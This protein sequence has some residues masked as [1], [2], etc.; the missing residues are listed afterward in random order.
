VFANQTVE[1]IKKDFNDD[2]LKVK[3][4]KPRGKWG[5]GLVVDMDQF[6]DSSVPV[7]VGAMQSLSGGGKYAGV[8][9]IKRLEIKNRSS[10]AVNSVQL[11]WKI[12]TLDDPANVLL[13]G[14]TPFFNFW[15]GANSSQVVEIPTVYPSLLFKPLAKDGGLN[16]Q[17]KLT[18]GVQEAYFA[19]GSFWRRQV[20]VV[21][22]N[23]LY[24]D[25]TVANQ[26]PSLASIN[27]ILPPLWGGNRVIIRPCEAKPR[28]SASA[29]SSM[30]FQETTCQDDMSAWVNQDTG[31]QRVSY[32]MPQTD[33]CANL[34]R[35]NFD[36][37]TLGIILSNSKKAPVR[38]EMRRLTKELDSAKPVLRKNSFLRGVLIRRERRKTAILL[39][40]RVWEAVAVLAA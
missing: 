16:G 28:S 40:G 23:F 24:Y 36:Y 15:A 31:Q 10:K 8:V 12:T 14:T 18:I 5:F 13:E 7:A 39:D 38:W 35:H 3:E 9:K 11:R 30:P 32:L 1:D 37:Q 22:L 29:F 21:L 20:P 34:F 27:P 2:D 19:D 17:F 4:Q 25:Q 33:F 6:D 26:F